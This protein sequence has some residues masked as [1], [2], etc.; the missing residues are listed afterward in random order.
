MNC[1]IKD[2]CKFIIGLNGINNKN[3]KL[4]SGLDSVLQ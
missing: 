3:C 1:R 4:F 2:N